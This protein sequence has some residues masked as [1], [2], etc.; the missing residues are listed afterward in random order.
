MILNLSFLNKE[1]SRRNI[2]L[3]SHNRIINFNNSI[4]EHK[5]RYDLFISHSYLDKKLILTLIELF[6]EANYSVYVDWINDKNMDRSNVTVE[7]AKTIKDR[8]SMCKGLAY[9]STSNISKSKWCPWELGLGDGL[10]N[11]R[12]SI[13]P[14]LEESNSRYKGREYLSIYP[15]IIY[16]KVQGSNKDEFWVIDTKDS[17]KY[18]SLKGWLNGKNPFSHE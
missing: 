9:I 8:I 17:D 10:L 1:A 16:E 5:N 15:Y 18:V 3:E 2:F 4:F 6:N 7:T 13:L 12:A 14:I 11:G